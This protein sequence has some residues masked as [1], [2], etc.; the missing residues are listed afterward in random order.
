MAINKIS[1]KYI[2][3]S[4][5]AVIFIVLFVLEVTNTTYIFHSHK[6]NPIIPSTSSKPHNVSK[7]SPSNTGKSANAATSDQVPPTSNGSQK[8]T[9]PSSPQTQ[10]ITPYGTFVSNHNPGKDGSPTSEQSVCNTNPAAICYI[11]FTKD[12]ITKTLQP[13]AADSSGVVYWSWD[14]NNAKDI[15]LTAGSWQVSAIASLNGQTKS[16]DDVVPLEIQ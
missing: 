5:L 12:G 14:V 16:S 4:V 6:S 8:Q 15:G 10:L 3:I 13:Q 2:Y 11:K 1:R 9:L 7:N